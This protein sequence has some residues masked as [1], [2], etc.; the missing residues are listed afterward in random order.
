M[1]RGRVNSI[2]PSPCCLL[3]SCTSFA[4]LSEF[5]SVFLLW[6]LWV[7]HIKVQCNGILMIWD[8]YFI[9]HQ[10]ALQIYTY[11]LHANPSHCC[12]SYPHK[13]K[14]NL[15]FFLELIKACIS[16][17][18]IKSSFSA[19]SSSKVLIINVLFNFQIS[20]SPA[21]LVLANIFLQCGW[22][23]LNLWLIFLSCST[24]HQ[25]FLSTAL[26]PISL[27]PLYPKFVDSSVK[28]LPLSHKKVGDHLQISMH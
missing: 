18:T 22:C 6:L 7:S 15:L 28:K 12:I 4:M 2:L 14:K 25:T 16:L 1:R 21:S 13:T 23:V 10:L 3:S 11:N 5:S 20:R 9:S 26:S 24:F 27:K 17:G 19:G 8:G